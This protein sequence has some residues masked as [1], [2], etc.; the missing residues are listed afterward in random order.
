MVGLLTELMFYANY[1][2]DLYI[3]RNRMQPTPPE[4][5]KGKQIADA[6]VLRGYKQLY[7]GYCRDCFSTIH[8]AMLTDKLHS[9]IAPVTQELLALMNTGVPI[10]SIMISAMPWGRMAAHIFRK[11]YDDTSSSPGK[12]PNR[13]KSDPG[14]LR[15]H[16]DPAGR[17]RDP[18]GSRLT[19]HPSGWLTEPGGC[20]AVFLTH[21][22]RDHMGLAEQIHPDI[23]L[24]L[25]YRAWKVLRAANQYLGRRTPRPG[26]FSGART[27]HPDRRADGHP[28]SL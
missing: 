5:P 17:R 1:M 18:E 19:P 27:P 22:H 8:A 23:P 21:T 10:F 20:D 28:L 24:Y 12:K 14:D 9:L 2:Y 6:G 4:V 25:G 13:G 7:A 11:A 26:R 3:A 16:E 15:R